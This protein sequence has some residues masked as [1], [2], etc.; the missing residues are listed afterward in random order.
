MRAW[1]VRQAFHVNLSQNQGHFTGSK[2]QFYLCAAAQLHLTP[3]PAL[4]K[5]S[6]TH[7]SPAAIRA[8]PHRS[9]AVRSSWTASFVAAP[10]R[11]FLV[12]VSRFKPQRPHWQRQ[13]YGKTSRE[14]PNRLSHSVHLQEQEEHCQAGERHVSG[15]AI[16]GRLFA[17]LLDL[18]PVL[19][20][21]PK[22]TSS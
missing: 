8:N 12:W 22:A 15:D 20:S 2:R 18:L 14:M 3:F 16:H 4:P 5:R 7:S 17:H 1:C 6:S 10:K 9:V 19:L 21:R 11:P 13:S